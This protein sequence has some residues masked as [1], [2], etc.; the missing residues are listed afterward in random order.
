VTQ[1]VTAAAPG[2][3]GAPDASEQFA[4]STFAAFADAFDA[5]ALASE[6]RL[7]LA[8]RALHVRFVAPQLDARFSPTLAHLV[9]TRDVDPPVDLRVG[10]WDR[11]LTDVAVPPPPWGLDDYLPEA[12]IRGHLDGRI[13][14]TFDATA[15]ILSLYD[16]D[17]R[18]AVVH[19][20]D[21]ATVP[22]W[23]DRA[24]FRTILTWWA[25]DRGFV[26][27]HASAVA[28]GD[29]AVVLAGGTGAGKSTTALACLAAGLD[30][31][32][33][34]ACLVGLDPAPRV[35]SVYKRAKLE[36][37]AALWLPSLDA[38]AVERRPDQTHIDPGVHHRREAPL[39]AVLLPRV[40]GATTTRA[41]PMKR[42]EAMGVLAATTLL[43]GGAMAREA[44]ATLTALARDVPCLRL[45]L[46][47]ELDGVADT[48]RTV[49]EEHR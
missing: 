17:A 22:D 33:D 11:S 27:L 47:R 14:A 45:E 23:M 19:V 37:D 10:F 29:G 3:P 7:R 8:G 26:L 36:P 2:A 39:L 44:L 1:G 25:A 49:I 46:G 31:L 48:V 13:R 41:T 6:Q 20:A 15:R 21:S 42:T 40:T 38:L 16:R 34:D 18:E 30:L 5:S 9:D 24:P 43:E 4:R 35:W 12:R 32:G 28:W